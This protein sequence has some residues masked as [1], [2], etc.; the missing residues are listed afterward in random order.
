MGLWRGVLA[1]AVEVFGRVWERARARGGWLAWFRYRRAEPSGILIKAMLQITDEISLED[2]EIVVK[3]VRSGGPGGQHVNKVATAVQLR[4]DAAGS[5]S[6]PDDVRER[7]TEL[8]GNRM[9]DDG[10]LTIEASRFRSQKRNRE[11]AVERLVEL[12]RRAAEKPK[13][14]RDTK[15]T[16]RAVQRRLQDKRRRATVKDTRRTVHEED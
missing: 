13:Q 8:A 10:I 5:S 16:A 6:L 1:S 9:S 14:R 7:L 12:L 2:S 4:F 15:P 3:F 11:D